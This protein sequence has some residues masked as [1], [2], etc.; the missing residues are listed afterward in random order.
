LKESADLPS[1]VGSHE[2][3]A[4]KPSR[5][6][7]FLGQLVGVAGIIQLAGG[8]EHDVGGIR[9][10]GEEGRGRFQKPGGALRPDIAGIGEVLENGGAVQEDADVVGPLVVVDARAVY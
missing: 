1:E 5:Q 6:V 2:R 8:L 7:R 3:R 9:E 10:R 4:S